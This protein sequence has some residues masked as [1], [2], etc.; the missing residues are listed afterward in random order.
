MKTMKYI[1]LI[2]TSASVMFFTACGDNNNIEAKK[3]SLE[4]L[5]KQALDINAQIATLEKDLAKAGAGDLAKSILVS[6]D[7]IKVQDFIH[8][9]ELQGK[10][11][12]ESVSN[13]TPKA[14]GGQV[15]AV[16][17]KRGDKVK[18]GQ[19]LL[20][21]DNTLIKQQVAAAAQNLEAVKAQA[22]LAKSVYDKQ[23]V[24]GNKILEVK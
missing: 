14:G 9:I 10:V 21:L 16:L 12:S 7:S 24:Y 5:K 2:L 19:L 6:I 1:G 20:Q 3:A 18:K 17:V 13:V 11:E 8:Y 4:K 22:A 15:K 23:K